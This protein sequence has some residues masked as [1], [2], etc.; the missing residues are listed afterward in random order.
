MWMVNMFKVNFEVAGIV[1][2]GVFSIST[3]LDQIS[4]VA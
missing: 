4:R 1:G 3:W 2:V